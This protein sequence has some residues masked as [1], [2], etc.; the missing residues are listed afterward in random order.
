[1]D[2]SYFPSLQAPGAEDFA[3][4]FSGY[5]RR[6]GR[7]D[8]IRS[9][10]RS[11][12]L[13]ADGF[14]RLD[15]EHWGFAYAPGKWTVKQMLQHLSDTERIFAFRALHI[16]RCDP[17]PLPGMDQDDYVRASNPEQAPDQLLREYRAIRMATLELFASFSA[18]AWLQRG[19]VE[20]LSLSCR[21]IP[22]ILAGHE[23]H[24]LDV[25]D[26]KYGLAF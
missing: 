7:Q 1:M 16:A 20:G 5:I 23:L 22:F 21:A 3:P 2:L 10:V 14:A 24:H 17:N 6:I 19:R 9:L 8:P 4:F 26:Q 18:E 15:P 11:G 13:V 12:Q 25:L